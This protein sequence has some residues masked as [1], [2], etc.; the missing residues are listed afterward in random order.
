MRTLKRA[1][2]EPGSELPCHPDE[3][4]KREEVYP[5]EDTDEPTGL[6]VWYYEREDE[7]GLSTPEGQ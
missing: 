5:H 3:I 4:I 1:Y 7:T 2:L 6:R